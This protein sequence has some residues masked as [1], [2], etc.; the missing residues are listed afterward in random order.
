M[1]KFQALWLVGGIL[2]VLPATMGCGSNSPSGTP[3]SSTGG[4]NAGATGG[5][6]STDACKPLQLGGATAAP[7]GI[8][9]LISSGSQDTVQGLQ[10][11]NGYLYF[12]GSKALM[13]IP[14]AGGTPEVVD[15]YSAGDTYFGPFV[16]T[17]THAV[18]TEFNNAS[19]GN[20]IQFYANTL[21]PAGAAPIALGQ[22]S[23]LYDLAAT[24]SAVFWSDQSSISTAPIA[25]GSSTVAFAN[26]D[27]GAMLVLGSYLYFAN[28]FFGT[29]GDELLRMPVAGGTPE[30][31][32]SIGDSGGMQMASDGQNLYWTSNLN[33]A[34]YVS[35]W[36][37]AG[38]DAKSLSIMSGPGAYSNGAGRLAA[39][40]GIAYY[41]TSV[42]CGD[43]GTYLYGVAHVNGDGTGNA[44]D[45][46]G[47][48][49]PTGIAV[50]ATYVYVAISSQV[51]ASHIYR[52]A[53]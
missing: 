8:I 44:V 31:L 16:V 5:A 36:P 32:A 37:F 33:E 51:G 52:F 2:C 9:D 35:A 10:L 42:S 30:S 53:R 38:G 21:A 18:W 29:P 48:D 25:G 7:R 47:L 13:R 6:T 12:E 49:Q 27:A 50:D 19:F 40:S 43:A 34:L 23:V 26:A 3:S 28:G 4:T 24:D 20:G 22:T 11:S 15:S 45:I 1:R 46:Q 41:T 39:I 14:V 17:D